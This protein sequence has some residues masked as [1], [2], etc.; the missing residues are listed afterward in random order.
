MRQA[1]LFPAVQ[2]TNMF[3]FRA[4]YGA[5]ALVSVGLSACATAGTTKPGEPSRAPVALVI[6]NRNSMNSSITVY[7]VREGTNEKHRL[8]TVRLAERKSFKFSEYFNGA[9]YRFVARETGG[10]EWSSDPFLI[11]PGDQ[12]EWRTHRA[13]V[14]VEEGQRSGF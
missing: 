14:W 11:T 6:D 5:L 9:R 8:G 12:A 7:V 13:V 3:Q 1:R 2:E 4:I 10:S